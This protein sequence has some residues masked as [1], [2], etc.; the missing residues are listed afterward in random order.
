M[1]GFEAQPAALKKGPRDMGS[2]YKRGN[3][4][5]IKYYVNGRPT[6]ESA[7]TMKETE[8]RRFLKGREGRHLR[9]ADAK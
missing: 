4:W 6:Q 2:L 8:A 9:L 5:W 7:G 3:S 1:V